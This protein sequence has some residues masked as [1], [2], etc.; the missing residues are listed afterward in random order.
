VLARETFIDRGP[1]LNFTVVRGKLGLGST[2]PPVRE[3]DS[4][5]AFLD[6]SGRQFIAAWQNFTPI[7]PPG[8]TDQALSDPPAYKPI[9]W[10]V[11]NTLD[12][13]TT[14]LAAMTPAST[15]P[16]SP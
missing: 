7:P 4:E 12:A 6:R 16:T 14:A 13:Y 5:V 15:T 11:R 3:V 2:K 9:S 8:V 10:V 1:S